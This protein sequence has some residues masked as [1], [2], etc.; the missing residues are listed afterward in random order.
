MR[1]CYIRVSTVEQNDQRQRDAFEKLNID[2]SLKKRR[3]R[4]WKVAHN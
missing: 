4:I 3:E 1:I 2:I